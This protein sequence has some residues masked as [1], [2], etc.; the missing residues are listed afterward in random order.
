MPIR[1][2]GVISIHPD[3]SQPL[4]MDLRHILSTLGGN[5]G[6]WIW[7]VKKLDWLGDDGEAFC[8]AV[9]AAGPG[10][11]WIDSHDLVEKAKGIYQTIEGEFLA[12]PRSI[13]RRNVR[14]IDL[15]LLVY[16]AETIDEPGLTVPHPRLAERRFALEPLAELAP[17]LEIPGLGSVQ[18][19]LAELE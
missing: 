3:P 1:E 16:G 14:T 19:L 12:F 17:E 4:G 7:C 2:L 9:E 5:L 15:D 8:A 11:L 13:D 6:D 10:G 18:A